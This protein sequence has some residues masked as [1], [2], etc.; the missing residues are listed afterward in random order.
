MSLN[1]LKNDRFKRN[2]EKLFDIKLI[3]SKSEL[4]TKSTSQRSTN[5]T[6]A[7]VKIDQD[8]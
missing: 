5:Y 7:E 1:N 2:M 3:K 6:E 4:S 8:Q